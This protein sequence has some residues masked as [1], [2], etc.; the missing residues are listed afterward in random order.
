MRV[1]VKCGV[2]KPESEYRLNARKVSLRRDCISCEREQ[3]K[4]Y[5]EANKAR[6]A[7]YDKNRASKERRESTL[8][9]QKANR[10]RLRQYARARYRQNASLIIC[11][12]ANRRAAKADATPNW[13][14]K[15]ACLSIYKAAKAMSAIYERNYEVDHIVPLINKNVCG[16]H[17]PWNLR[18]CEKSENASKG[19]SFDQDSESTNYE[20]SLHTIQAEK[21]GYWFS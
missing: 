4:R 9:W 10:S 15:N 3:N 1:C 18:L 5:R 13:L 7:E 16:L 12:V 21:E 11:Q 19:N 8:R 20:R 6:L 2:S 14:P 17:V